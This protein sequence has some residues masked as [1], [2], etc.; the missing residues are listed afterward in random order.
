MDTL[1]T[2]MLF[3]GFNL[4]CSLVVQNPVTR[5]KD[6]ATIVVLRM[7]VQIMRQTMWAHFEYSQ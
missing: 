3:L 1:C 2:P 5:F 7:I 6:L 4:L